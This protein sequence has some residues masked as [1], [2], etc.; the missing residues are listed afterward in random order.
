MKRIG[1]IACVVVAALAAAAGYLAY[2]MGIFA[3]QPDIHRDVTQ[4]EKKQKATID[5]ALELVH[6]ARDKFAGVKDYRCTYLR[7]EMVN[8][9]MNKNHIILS[10]RHEPFSVLMEYVKPNPG[11]KAAYV[12]GQNDNQIMLKNVPL[13]KKIDPDGAF[14]KSQ[15]R[16]RITEAGLKGM[17]ERF[18]SRWA[19]EKELGQTDVAIQDVELKVD[20]PEGARVRPCRVVMTLHNPKDKDSGHYMFY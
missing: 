7:D 10:I 18:C 3:E 4:R 17:M 12:H 19:K 5:D 6:K 15:S 20:L 8:K 9:S 2:A 16:D 1:I 11:R 13:M 14:A